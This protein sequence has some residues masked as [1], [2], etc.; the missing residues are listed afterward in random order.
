M[1]IGAMSSLAAFAV[2]AFFDFNMQVPANALLVCVPLAILASP[3]RR[4]S[5]MLASV[6]TSRLAVASMLAAV[7]MLAWSAWKFLPA[8]LAWV[9]SDAALA[10]GNSELALEL[11]DSGML[12]NPK[13]SALAA[14]GGRV[15]L[16]LG[17]ENGFSEVER[18]RLLQRSVDLSSIA[19]QGEAG[20]AWHLMNLAH[21]YDNLGSFAQAAHLHRAAIA[22]APYY[23]TPYEFYALHLELSGQS[24]EAI[25]FYTLALHLPSSTFS[26]G[27]REA[28]LLAKKKTLSQ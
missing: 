13:H 6:F 9:R 25:R 4:V 19:M 8:E 24:D 5:S 11:A 10:H 20:D 22:Q 16:A 2:H 14:T 18:R 17:K 7:L 1:Q 28:L 15:A 27:R 23:A 3:G 12:A 21:A 26:A